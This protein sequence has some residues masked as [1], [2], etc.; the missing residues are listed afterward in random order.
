MSRNEVSSQPDFD[1]SVG[2]ADG[3]I[4]GV[5]S[6]VFPFCRG[7]FEP[8]PVV[9]DASRK[10]VV[11]AEGRGTGD[12]FGSKVGNSVE[13]ADFDAPVGLVLGV[14]IRSK[15]IGKEAKG[16]VLRSDRR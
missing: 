2:K 15:L 16:R 14:F 6:A 10:V 4:A 5:P 7:A 3:D 1:R 9:V 11:D 8:V 12:K 13:W